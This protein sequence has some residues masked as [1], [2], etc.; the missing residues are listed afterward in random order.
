MEFKIFR[1]NTPCVYIKGESKGFH[2]PYT[3][4]CL[5]DN[6][7]E[8]YGEG[9]FC[10]YYAKSGFA[11]GHVIAETNISWTE[12]EE[13]VTFYRAIILDCG[14]IRDLDD[15]YRSPLKFNADSIEEARQFFKKIV[16][17]DLFDELNP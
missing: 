15:T 14:Y 1:E 4:Y 13:T 16:S 5:V 7:P 10:G 17:K 9:D 6:D 2:S 12:D 11:D 8:F 3:H